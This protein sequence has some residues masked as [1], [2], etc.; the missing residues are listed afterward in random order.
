MLGLTNATSEPMVMIAK[1]NIKYLQTRVEEG[2]KNY[3]L[4]TWV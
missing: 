2:G 3:A 1:M 4:L